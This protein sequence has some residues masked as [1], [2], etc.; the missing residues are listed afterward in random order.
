MTSH[1]RKSNTAEILS[2]QT[3]TVE[4]IEKAL[5][6]DDNVL[7][8][9]TLNF[10]HILLLYRNENDLMTSVKTYMNE[11]LKREELCIHATVNL[12]NENYINTFTSQIENYQKNRKEGNLIMCNLQPYYKKAVAGNLKP[13]DK[14]AKLVAD[15]SKSDCIG[16]LDKESR[17]TNDCGS[18]LFKNGY[19][20]QCTDFETWLHQKPFTGTYLCT[21]PKSLFDTFPNDIYFSALAKCHDVVVDTKERKVTKYM[22]IDEYRR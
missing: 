5:K 9:S 14:F 21:Y 2:H 1:N 6:N 20:E 16:K 10:Q 15:K 12:M 13:F 7:G 17:I 18:L 8:S 11:G 19:F 22:N 4:K 3:R